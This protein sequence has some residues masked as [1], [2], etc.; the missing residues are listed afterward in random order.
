MVWSMHGIALY[1][2]QRH[3]RRYHRDPPSSLDADEPS[4]SL[5][6]AAFWNPIAE[7]K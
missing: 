1:N 6:P 2:R 3:T 5:K 7:R 4:R